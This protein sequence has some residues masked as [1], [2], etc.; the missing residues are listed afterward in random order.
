MDLFLVVIATLLGGPVIAGLTYAASRRFPHFLTPLASLAAAVLGVALLAALLKISFIS[1]HANV[2][3]LCL[4]YLAYCLLGLSACRLKRPL[5]RQLV[6]VAVS[7]P[8]ALGY[9]LGT[10]G[11]LGLAFLLGD[12]VGPP[13]EQRW[14]DGRT[15]CVVTIQDGIGETSYQLSLNQRW[16]GLPL[17]RRLAR[18]SA[19]DV[20]PADLLRCS[21]TDLAMA[22]RKL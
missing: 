3:A 5:L 21:G 2:V 18:I 15:I 22:R 9:L 7:M 19:V 20:G 13:V 17:Q 4:T 11:A 8:I 12:A 6:L 1:G 10:I 16:S 14:I